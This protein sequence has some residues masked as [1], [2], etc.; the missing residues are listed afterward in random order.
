MDPELLSK[1][2]SAVAAHDYLTIAAAAL[3]VIVP[4]VL[5]GLKIE[6]PV[7]TALLDGLA[8][9]LPDDSAKLPKASEQPGLKAVVPVQVEAETKKPTDGGAA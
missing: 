8:K 3:V 7:V 6:V 1:V 2:Q 9:M 4:L 5:H